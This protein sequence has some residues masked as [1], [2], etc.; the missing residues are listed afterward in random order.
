MCLFKKCAMLGEIPWRSRSGR[1]RPSCQSRAR[2]RRAPA[3][4][5]PTWAGS[6]PPPH[7][8]LNSLDQKGSTLLDNTCKCKRSVLN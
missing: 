1:R 6:R 3:T 2:C 5:P 8:C 4:A 7:I